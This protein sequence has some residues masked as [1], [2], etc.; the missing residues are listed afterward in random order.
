MQ[1]IKGYVENG[2]FHPLGA[3][4]RLPIRLKAILTILDEPVEVSKLESELEFWRGIDRLV[5]EAADE[6]MPEFPRL[7]FGRELVTFTEE[8]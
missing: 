4:A 5:D 6:A 8:D 7:D 2:Q 1:A 3:I